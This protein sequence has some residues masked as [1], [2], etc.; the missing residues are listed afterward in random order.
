MDDAARNPDVSISDPTRQS[1]FAGF[2]PWPSRAILGLL[3]AIMIWAAWQPA[4]QLRGSTDNA[5]SAS[6]FS[7]AAPPAPA[8]SSADDNADVHLYE[9]MIARVAQGQPYHAAM[10]DEL[11]QHNYPLKPFVTF[12]L[13][14]L[15]WFGAAVPQP[16]RFAMM[17]ALAGAAAWSWRARL[18]ADGVDPSRITIGAMLVILGSITMLRHD[19]LNWHEAWAGLLI[20]LALAL[21]RAERWWPTLLITALAV[22]VRETSILFAAIMG[23]MAVHDRRWREAMGWI[24]LALGFAIVMAWHAQQVAAVVLASDPPS[25]G[26]SGL[27]G[28]RMAITMLRQ[29]GALRA[30]PFFVSLIAIPIM[31]I[32]WAGWRSAVGVRGAATLIAYATLFALACRPDNFY[33]AFLV[34]PLLPIGLLFCVAALDDLWRNARILTRR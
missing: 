27:G 12:R 20:A 4:V 17:I 14:T 13:P 28:P 32:G 10:A 9:R 1:R 30:V 34:A 5:T 11:R 6:A 31:L 33:W 19:L 8:T 21:Y 2:G 15:T 23:V 16:V 18:R 26:W 3:A 29:T 24:A 7:S 25:P 22:A